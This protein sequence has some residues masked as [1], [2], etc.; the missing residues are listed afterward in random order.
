[1]IMIQPY[2]AYS[3]YM[4]IKLHFERD[5]YDALKYNFKTSATP[6]SFFARKDKF[7]FA[8]IAKKF[9]ETTDLVQYYV[10][11]FARDVKWV[12]DMLNENGDENYAKWK[13]YSEALTYRFSSDLDI[14][15]HYIDMNGGKFDDLFII[16]DGDS[17][18]P[19][20]RLLLQ[21]DI[22]LETAVILEKMLGFT[23]RLD[24]KI[25]E[26]L[27]WPELSLKIRKY[28]PFVNADMSNLKKIT[29]EK[30]A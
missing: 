7:Y 27:V 18:P 14:L 16:P 1:M 9:T 30:F 2:D 26:T 20:V 4:A 5:S 12:G 22:S 25:R 28:T 10:S 29:L 11:N 23:K 8:K 15:V 21:E 19:I 24:K 17:H 13:K 3:Y 6:K